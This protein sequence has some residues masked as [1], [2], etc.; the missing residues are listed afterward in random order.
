MNGEPR[1]RT[2]T[3]RSGRKKKKRSDAEKKRRW[4]GKRGVEEELR[5]VRVLFVVYQSAHAE[6][7]SSYCPK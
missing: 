1:E 3:C 6:V 2:T 4:A 7:I 5:R